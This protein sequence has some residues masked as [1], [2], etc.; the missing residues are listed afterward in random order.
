MEPL[1]LKGIFTNK[2]SPS[3]VFSVILPTFNRPALLK[4]SV[5]SVLA[6]SFKQFELII[7]DDASQDET[8]KTIT[9]FHDPRIRY[10][11]LTHNSGVAAA[12]NKGICIAKGFYVSFLDD[13]DEFSID[14]LEKTYQVFKG[15][16][17]DTGF[18]W[19]GQIWVIDTP[20][21]ESLLAKRLWRP[22]PEANAEKRWMLFL[23][24][25]SIGTGCGLTVR[26]SCFLKAGMF[27]ESFQNG[28]DT[29]FLFRLSDHYNFT[30][31]P[32]YL[33]KVHTHSG[34]SL[35]ST[36]DHP[37]T[38]Y[39][40]I[41][42]RQFQ[43]FKN[44]PEALTYFLYKVGW[45]HYYCRNKKRGRRFMMMAFKAKPRNLKS[46]ASILLFEILGQKTILLYN[47]R[48]KNTWIPNE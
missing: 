32:E 18:A 47:Q 46:L 6:Q 22:E 37:G 24:S 19:S 38:I 48:I 3:P 15:K 45:W 17:N 27:D 2:M 13:D 30:V 40:K 34:T 21:G 20:D 9:T 11:R 44:S 31:I 12:R 25:L 41:L 8:P 26:R 29:E 5:K 42:Y 23:K 43:R 14:F 39:E 4:R 10:I 28:E 1:K 33:T 36:R 16:H 35:S 7:I